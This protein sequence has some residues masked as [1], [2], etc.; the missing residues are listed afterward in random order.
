MRDLLAKLRESAEFKQIMDELQRNRPVIPDYRPQA[1]RE[2]TE[3]LVEK[4]KYQSGLR[5]GF[6]LLSKLL[7]GR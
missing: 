2:E 6:D 5:D 1:T 4:I 7:T 3:Y